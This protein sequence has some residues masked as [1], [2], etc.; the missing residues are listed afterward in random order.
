MKR[1]IA[2]I[3]LLLLS[4][5][6][7]DQESEG[8]FATECAD[9]DDC[10]DDQICGADGGGRRVCVPELECTPGE[11]R[12]GCAGDF[13]VFCSSQTSTVQYFDCDQFVGNDT[14][15][16]LQPCTGECE[17]NVGVCLVG[18]GD[19]CADGSGLVF[20]SGFLICDSGSLACVFRQGAAET[21]EPTPLQC[22]ATTPGAQCI[23]NQLVLCFAL[24]DD[25]TFTSPTVFDCTSLG[26]TCDA[27]L[28]ACVQPSGRE[29]DTANNGGG[30][31]QCEPGRTCNG[32][33]AEEFQLGTCN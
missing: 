29:C 25:G 22:N 32:F 11:F 10:D 8:T 3:V 2:C 23:D 1:N 33:N 15:C 20:S 4:C 24:G 12:S 14:S 28:R 5:D 27:N 30:F 21:C 7:I 9:D 17:Q 18:D 19:P 31:L 16:D 26:G 6:E 13:R